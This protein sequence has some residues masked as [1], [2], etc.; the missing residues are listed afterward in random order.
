[1][2]ICRVCF[3]CRSIGRCGDGVVGDGNDDS[4]CLE[5][6]DRGGSRDK[7]G[8]VGDVGVGGSVEDIGSVKD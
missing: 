7:G 8:C 5:G 4:N 3:G 1:M 6:I 2:C